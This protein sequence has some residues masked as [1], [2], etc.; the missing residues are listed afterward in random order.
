MEKRSGV[1]G[2]PGVGTGTEE[3]GSLP[4]GWSEPR[5]RQ[6]LWPHFA[7]GPRH[8]MLSGHAASGGPSRPRGRARAAHPCRKLA[9]G[10]GT[11]SLGA[12]HGGG[13]RPLCWHSPG[14]PSG[15]RAWHASPAAISIPRAASPSPPGALQ[16]LSVTESPW[17]PSFRCPHCACRP[18][19][20]TLRRQLK[21]D[22]QGAAPQSKTHVLPV[23]TDHRTSHLQTKST[24]PF[25]AAGR[26]HPHRAQEGTPTS[27]YLPDKRHSARQFAQALPFHMQIAPSP[28]PPRGG[29]FRI[30][31]P[32]GGSGDPGP[33][34]KT[35]SLVV[36]SF[37]C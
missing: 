25:R 37:W 18:V 7:E 20:S 10:W 3:G 24:L 36:I 19:V 29:G 14:D 17:D 5:V 21:P 2:A 27:S 12:L 28:P 9:G 11:A 32:A 6:S 30:P 22:R 4:Q 35:S 1:R 23:R 31:S 15:H 33:G 8:C 34:I 26:P 16:G 13:C